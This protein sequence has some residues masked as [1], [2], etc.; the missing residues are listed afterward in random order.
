MKRSLLWSAVAVAAGIVHNY[1]TVRYCTEGAFAGLVQNGPTWLVRI[2]NYAFFFP[3]LAL[4]HLGLGGTNLHLLLAA[5]SVVWTA[6]ILGLAIGSRR[7]L[8]WWSAARRRKMAPPI[9]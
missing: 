3:L 1:A 4:S 8:T 2:I 7:L 5:N 9:T 6:T